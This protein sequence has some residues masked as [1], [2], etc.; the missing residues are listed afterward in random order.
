[1]ESFS[2][3]SKTGPA[4]VAGGGVSR[5]IMW[6]KLSSYAKKLKQEEEVKEFAEL[7]GLP[8]SNLVS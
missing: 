2:K 7:S 3:R 6:T 5:T 4:A 8:I 1:M